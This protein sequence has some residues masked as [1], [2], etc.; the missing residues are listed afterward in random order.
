MRTA[1]LRTYGARASRMGA[2]DSVGP[3]DETL[4]RVG[5]IP[6]GANIPFAVAGGFAMVED[7]QQIA[8]GQ[9]GR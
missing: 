8:A 1:P 9:I 6:R 3:G 4:A 2:R 5:R 7:G